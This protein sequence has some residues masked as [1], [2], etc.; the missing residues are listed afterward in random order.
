MFKKAE[1]KQAKLRL[2]LNG[3]SGSGKTWSALL[4]ATGISKKRIAVIDTEKGSASLYSDRFDFDTVEIEPPFTHDKYVKAI[5]FAEKSGEYDLLIV[6]SFSH[7]WMGEGG[8]KDQK[9]ILD[10]KPGSNHWT[11]WKKPKDN[12]N[13][14][15][16]A[17]LFSSLHMICTL[18]AK[19]SYEQ[20]T[21]DSGRKKIEKLGMDPQTEPGAEYDFTT[22]FDLTMSHHATV[23]K[24]RTGLFDGVLAIPTLET[25]KLIYDWLMSGKEVW[26]FGQKQLAEIKTICEGVKWTGV[27]MREESKRMFGGRNET[28]LDE[29]EFGQLCHS[30]G[31]K[32]LQTMNANLDNKVVELKNLPQQANNPEIREAMKEFDEAV[33][34]LPPMPTG[35]GV[36]K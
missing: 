14:L 17:I 5:E 8:T 9:D 18:R 19:Q 23:S 13:K 16:N 33:N 28:Q 22:V 6:D 3:P 15:K 25:G 7:A 32:G 4:I 31:L 29:K 24:D 2:G 30:I 10:L 34:A 12:Y 1:R 11:N 35:S 20:I 36:V 21:D 26:V 27:M